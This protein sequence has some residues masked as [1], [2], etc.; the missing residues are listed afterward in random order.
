MFKNK[1]RYIVFYEYKNGAITGKGIIEIGRKKIK[2]YSDLK[3][4]Q[5]SIKKE[6]GFQDVVITGY[7]KI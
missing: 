4:I 5:E 3:D 7:N 1:K 2:E 6:Y